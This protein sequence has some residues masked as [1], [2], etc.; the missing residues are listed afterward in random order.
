MDLDALFADLGMAVLYLVISLLGLAVAVGA[1]VFFFRREK[2]GDFKKYFIGIAA[3]IA[4]CALTVFTYIK[5]ASDIDK[6]SYG[7]VFYPVLAEIVIAVAGML[8]ILICSLFNK[9]AV[10]IAGIVTATL[11]LGGFIAMMVEMTKYYKI[12]GA[13]D[14]FN[15]VG[16][17]VS[18]VV[19]MA[20]IAIIY[21]IGDKRSISDTRAI[22]YGAIA[23]AMSFAL[24]YIRLFKLPQGGSLTLASLLPLM[25]YCCMFGTRRG[26]IACLIYGV[27]Q[28]IQ[29]P[30]I[31]HPMQFLLDYPLAFGMVGISGIFIEKKVFKIKSRVDVNN[32][33]GFACGAVIAITG[34]YICHVLS[35]IFAFASYSTMTS[36]LAYSLSYNSF[37]FVDLA[38]AMAAGIVLFMSKAFV[39]Q[40]SKSGDAGKRVAA[41]SV[42]P[43]FDDDDGFVYPDDEVP[44]QNEIDSAQITE[45]PEDTC[46]VED[47]CPV[48]ENTVS[49]QLRL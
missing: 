4:L 34:R 5:V 30:W 43:D 11:A 16:L 14:N 6:N 42:E 15:L 17:I 46:A 44:V 2:F 24:S 49:E 12:N 1:V 27:L 31:I 9:K 38:I 20:L 25:I 45:N 36:A 37:A 3:G 21:F 10:K 35:G 18:A 13:G 48:S 47:N 33:L 26:T 7:L 32:V 28:A 41:E 22:V 39:S 40:M 8:A 29:D 19:F 23:I